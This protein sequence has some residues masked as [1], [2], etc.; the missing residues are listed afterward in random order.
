M[1]PFLRFPIR[2]DSATHARVCGRRI[3]N[4]LVASSAKTNPPTEPVSHYFPVGISPTLMK[5]VIFNGAVL[6]CSDE[7]RWR[8]AVFL[9][10]VAWFDWALGIPLGWPH[11]QRGSHFELL[12]L[13][14][15]RIV[16]VK[17]NPAQALYSPCCCF[18]IGFLVFIPNS[19]LAPILYTCRNARRCWVQIIGGWV[20]V[21]DFVRG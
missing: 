9:Y 15:N 13:R 2:A 4:T 7:V 1:R 10:N 12:F 3:F 20:H 14:C 17:A 5:H 11:I 18:R 21:V 16:L 19:S 8:W 6:G